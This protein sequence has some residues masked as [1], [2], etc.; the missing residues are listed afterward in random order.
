VALAGWVCDI[1]DHLGDAD[2]EAQVA[3]SVAKLCAEY[4]VYRA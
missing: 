4:P 1:L 2:V 3:G